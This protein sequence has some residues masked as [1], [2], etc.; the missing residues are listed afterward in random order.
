[1][2]RRAADIQIVRVYNAGPID[3]DRLAKVLCRLLSS[4][5]AQGEIDKANRVSEIVTATSPEKII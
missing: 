5:D 2:G 4:E 3:E 1:M